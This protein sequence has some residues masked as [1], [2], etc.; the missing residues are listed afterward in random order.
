MRSGAYASMDAW[1]ADVGLIWANCRKYNGEAHPVSKLA[2]KLEAAMER[3]MDEAVAAATREL[4][5]RGEASRGGKVKTSREFAGPR[6]SASDD[7]Q[8]DVKP[9]LPRVVSLQAI[10]LLQQLY[11]RLHH[12]LL[13]ACQHDTAAATAALLCLTLGMR[14]CRDR[15]KES[16]LWLCC[17]G[18]V[19][20]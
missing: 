3:R 17:R 1:K 20:A 16:A 6:T 4:A 12:A 15:S 11:D 18:L 10:Q 9:S 14:S 2:E 7:S 13:H 5:Q 8:D 19:L